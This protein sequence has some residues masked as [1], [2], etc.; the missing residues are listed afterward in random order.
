VNVTASIANAAIVKMG[1]GGN[2]VVASSVT[3]GQTV[4]WV[5]NYN[6]ASTSQIIIS[7]AFLGSQ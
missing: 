7:L 4:G 1:T 3:D 5:R 2:V 6:G